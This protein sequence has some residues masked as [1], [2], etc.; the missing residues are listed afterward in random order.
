M[1]LPIVF[2]AAAQAELTDA[3][4]WY[5]GQRPGRGSDLVAEVRAVLAMISA[6]PDRY[7]IV[8]RD[9]REASVPRFPYCIYYRVK[10][11]RV[12]VI[13]VVHTARDPSVWQGRT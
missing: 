3:A 12:V 5:D 7:P 10:P 4:V 1:S 9:V 11:D 8:A 2:R 6:Q 13:A